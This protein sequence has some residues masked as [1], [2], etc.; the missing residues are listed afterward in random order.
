MNFIFYDGISHNKYHP[1]FYPA[2]SILTVCL[3]LIRLIIIKSF[4]QSVMLHYIPPRFL[5]VFPH[6]GYL[7]CFK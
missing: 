4:V 7:L 5:K 6:F 3:T 1:A 2:V